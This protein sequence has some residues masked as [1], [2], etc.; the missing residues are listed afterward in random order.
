MTI[1]QP[2]KFWA[3]CTIVSP[4]AISPMA[5]KVKLL[6]QSWWWPDQIPY[7][8]AIT[9]APNALLWLSWLQGHRGC[10]YKPAACDCRGNDYYDYSHDHLAHCPL[11][12]STEGDWGSESKKCTYSIWLVWYSSIEVFNEWRSWSTRWILGGIVEN[13]SMT[14]DR[15]WD[16]KGF[17]ILLFWGLQ[18]VV[19]IEFVWTCSCLSIR[20]VQ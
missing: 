14:E 4:L 3:N 16:N 8:F 11:I 18:W 17:Q 9:L 1:L 7:V 15:D 2:L 5:L 19:L 12:A 20:K 13:D 10:D 6:M